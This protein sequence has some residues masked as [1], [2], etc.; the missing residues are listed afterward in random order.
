MTDNDIGRKIRDARLNKG[1]TQQELA[2]RVGVHISLISFYEIGTKKL[3]LKSKYHL[4]KV[5]GIDLGC[6]D[7][8]KLVE[9]R[10]ARGY[11]QEQLAISLGISCSFLKKIEQEKAWIPNRI[12]PKLNQL[13]GTDFQCVPQ[14]TGEALRQARIT[15]GRNQTEVAIAMKVSQNDISSWELGLH[16]I[17]EKYTE[18]LI[19]LLSIPIE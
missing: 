2:D 5:L 9:R 4:Q 7:L 17:P 10:I 12:I 18:K 14:L 8:P 15:K 3:S 11:T 1:Y 13:L 16:K 19:A 6:R